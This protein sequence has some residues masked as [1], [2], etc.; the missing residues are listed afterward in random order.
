MN[1]LARV[2]HALV[3]GEEATHLADLS[4]PEQVALADLRSFLCMPP[5]DLAD[6]LA[7]EQQ[8][9]DWWNPHDLPVTKPSAD[10][11]C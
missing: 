11:G 2:V 1:T 6:F 9:I 5:Q 8:P 3:T 4:S 7:Q 10:S